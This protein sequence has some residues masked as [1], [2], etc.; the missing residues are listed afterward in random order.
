MLQA[1]IKKAA[2]L[3]RKAG[4]VVLDTLREGDH[5]RRKLGSMIFLNL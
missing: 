2:E 3:A 5:R 1:E 4:E